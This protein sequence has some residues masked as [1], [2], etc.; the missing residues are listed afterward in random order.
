MRYIL[1]ALAIFTSFSQAVASITEGG[2]CMLF[3]NDHAFAFTAIPGWVLDN[4]SG[5]SQELHMVFYPT[6]QTWRYSP[7]II[8][9]RAVPISSAK[10]IESQVAVTV[11]D[12]R[13]NGST[14]YKSG[15]K[16]G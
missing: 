10:N 13:S 5:L 6:R 2:R 12:F 3:G 16:R 8:Y 14:N 9:G 1:A 11:S 4:E 7:V 15:K